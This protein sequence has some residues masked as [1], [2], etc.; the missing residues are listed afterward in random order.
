MY[1][2]EFWYWWPEVMSILRPESSFTKFRFQDFVS[3]PE[4]WIWVKLDSDHYKAMGK[5]LNAVFFEGMSEYVL[6]IPRY[7]HIDHSR[8]PIHSFDPMTSLS[9]HPR[10]YEVI[11]HLT[12]DRTE[13][14]HWEW[15]QS[16]SFA[17]MHQLICNMTYLAQHVT[18]HDLDLRSNSGID[19]LRSTCTYF[20]EFWQEE[21]NAA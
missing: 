12:F 14:E 19:Y 15:S 8:W 13:M 21:H 17:N 16:V 7:S 9:G 11:F 6:S 5:C 20:D 3:Y 2:S 10:S 4:T 1:I 18:P